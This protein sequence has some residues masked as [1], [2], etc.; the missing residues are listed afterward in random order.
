MEWGRYLTQPEGLRDIDPGH[1]PDPLPLNI[2]DELE[3]TKK[4][5][6][7]TNLTKKD[8]ELN[9]IRTEKDLEKSKE[10]NN[11]LRDDLSNL[12][13]DFEK[14]R[15]DNDNLRNECQDAWK[16]ASERR[17]D[18]SS[19]KQQLETARAEAARANATGVGW[20]KS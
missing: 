18:I 15:K 20:S 3:T 7:D 4:E 2:N 13:N 11:T 17:D 5:L 12:K 1:N 8:V 16:V 9:L 10:E 6:D 14:A 19:L